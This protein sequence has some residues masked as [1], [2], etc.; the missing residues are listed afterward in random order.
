MTPVRK[1]MLKVVKEI[2]FKTQRQVDAHI[3]KWLK[4]GSKYTTCPWRDSKSAER[5]PY[6]YHDMQKI[7]QTMLPGKKISCTRDCPCQGYK[8][9]YVIHRAKEALK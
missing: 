9:A 8:T 1:R 4:S 7:C 2:E 6:Y 5:V 3:R